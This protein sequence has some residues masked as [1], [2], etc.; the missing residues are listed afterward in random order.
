[1]YWSEQHSILLCLLSSF[2]NYCLLVIN[3]FITNHSSKGCLSRGWTPYSGW[4]R[5]W[6]I[7]VNEQVLPSM[8][9]IW[10]TLFN[11]ADVWKGPHLLFYLSQFAEGSLCVSVSL[12]TVTFLRKGLVNWEGVFCDGPEVILK[13]AGLSFVVITLWRKTDQTSR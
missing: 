1:M 13:R 6:F 8:L 5:L 11:Q 12:G 4:F 3:I 10:I 7:C 9:T 2:S